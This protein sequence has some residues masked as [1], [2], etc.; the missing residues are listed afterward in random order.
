MLSATVRPLPHIDENEDES[1]NFRSSSA[2]GLFDAG[3]VVWDKK[4]PMLGQ[5]ASQPKHEYIIWRAGTQGPIYLRGAAFR[6]IIEKAKQIISEQ[7][8][9]TALAAKNSRSG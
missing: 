5:R 9:V 7:G 6:E 2:R 8:G 3:T 4:N 1:P